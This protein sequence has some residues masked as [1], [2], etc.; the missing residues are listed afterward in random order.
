MARYAVDGL[1]RHF[2]LFF[3]GS[4]LSPVVLMEF[5]PAGFEVIELLHTALK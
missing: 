2:V 5:L 1:L 4:V 3:F